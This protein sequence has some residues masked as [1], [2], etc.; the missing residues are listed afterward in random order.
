[1]TLKSQMVINKKTKQVI[2]TAF[3]NGKRHDFRVF[4][5]SNT[6]IN[7]DIK[8][9]TDTGYQIIQKLHSKSELPKK[10]TRHNPLTK[11]A[12][13]KNHEIASQRVTN[14]N[15][16]GMIKRFKIYTALQGFCLPL[17]IQYSG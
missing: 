6:K 4:K 11:E 5:D 14:E 9:I 12:K 15:V 1:M 8:V 16:I 10:K 17:L 2:C 7:P 3:V 13:K